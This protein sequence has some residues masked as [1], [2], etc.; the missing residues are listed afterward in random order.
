MMSAPSQLAQVLLPLVGIFGG[1]LLLLG[2]FI[3][4]ARIQKHFVRVGCCLSGSCYIIW[5]AATLVARIARLTSGTDHFL[6]FLG[7]R[8]GAAGLGVS[9]LLV[10]SGG[11]S[12]RPP[13]S[14]DPNS[15]EFGQRQQKNI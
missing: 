9:V 12:G 4:R 13:R 8:I 3:D 7:S 1:V 11:F 6:S 10:L 14:T 2:P 5:G 15:N